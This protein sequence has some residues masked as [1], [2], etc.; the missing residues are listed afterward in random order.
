MNIL[1]T[2]RTFVGM[3]MFWIRWGI[4]ITLRRL[5]LGEWNVFIVFVG[6]I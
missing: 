4:P 5:K 2:Y 1:I 3:G 6:M